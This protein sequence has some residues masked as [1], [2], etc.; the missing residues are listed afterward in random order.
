MKESASGPLFL[1]YEVHYIYIY[2]CVHRL[3]VIF[4]S[5]QAYRRPHSWYTTSHR[6]VHFMGL[7]GQS[8]PPGESAARR[9]AASR[10]VYVRPAQRPQTPQNRW[11][12]RPTHAKNCFKL[13]EGKWEGVNVVLTNSETY[14][15][16]QTFLLWRRWSQHAQDVFL[17]YS[18]FIHEQIR[19]IKQNFKA[20]M[21]KANG[22]RK[23]V[24]SF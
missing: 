1:S 15:V 16:T 18:F 22:N 19:N 3:K 8:R 13:S 9:N 5:T 6:N 7:R 17:H 2:V 20:I 24:E 11:P 21:V 12:N 14:G 10:N 23:L 4:V